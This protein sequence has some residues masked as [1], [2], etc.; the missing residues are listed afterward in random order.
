MPILLPA[1]DLPA[2]GAR[3][4]RNSIDDATAHERVRGIKLSVGERRHHEG[5][6]GPTQIEFDAANMGGTGAVGKQIVKILPLFRTLATVH[7][8]RVSTLIQGKQPGGRT[9]IN[10]RQS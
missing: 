6:C 5:Y 8:V 3:K 10:S 2:S 4:A 7:T 1:Q 9:P